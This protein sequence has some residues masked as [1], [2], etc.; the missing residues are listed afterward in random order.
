MQSEWPIPLRVAK[1]EIRR[2]ILFLEDRSGD[3]I[4]NKGPLWKKWGRSGNVFENKGD[5]VSKRECH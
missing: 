1:R 5:S 2:R 3:V 4:E